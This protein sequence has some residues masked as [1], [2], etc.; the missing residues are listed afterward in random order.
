MGWKHELAS[1]LGAAS[2]NH[3]CPKCKGDSQSTCR[4]FS[5]VSQCVSISNRTSLFPHFKV[6]WVNTFSHTLQRRSAASFLLGCQSAEQSMVV[7]APEPEAKVRKVELTVEVRRIS[8][9]GVYWS[10]SWLI[11][12]NLKMAPGT[13]SEWQLLEHPGNVCQQHHCGCEGHF[14]RLHANA[15]SCH[16]MKIL[17]APHSLASMQCMKIW[18][19]CA[20][21]RAVCRPDLRELLDD[22]IWPPHEVLVSLELKVCCEK[23]YSTL[24]PSLA[25]SSHF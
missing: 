12:G 5:M 4:V 13:S 25:T 6:R 14:F 1:V 7:E 10:P 3:A 18:N 23:I 8:H 9:E 24:R 11:F 16:C 2:S 15:C 20:L 21:E 19:N 17:D 22:M